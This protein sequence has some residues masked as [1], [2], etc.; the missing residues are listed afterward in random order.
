MQWRPH[1]SC[2]RKWKFICS[3]NVKLFDNF[4]VKKALIKSVYYF[5]VYNIFNVTR[6]IEMFVKGGIP[7]VLA[8]VNI[9]WSPQIKAWW[10]LEKWGETCCRI[11]LYCKVVYD[12]MLNTYVIGNKTEMCHL[13]QIVVSPLQAHKAKEIQTGNRQRTSH[14]WWHSLCLYY[15]YVFIV[16]FRTLSVIKAINYSV[17]W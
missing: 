11:N 17:E 14:R 6:C 10:K 2:G 4:K 3:R 15:L 7:F 16:Y 13:K 8:A 9:H 12:G 5:S 1:F